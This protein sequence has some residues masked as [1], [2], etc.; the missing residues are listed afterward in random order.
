[1]ERATAFLLLAKPHF[2]AL[3]ITESDQIGLTSFNEFEFN[4]FS[5]SDDSDT[6]NR[7]APGRFDS[8]GTEGADYDFIYGTGY[9]PLRAGE[10]QRISLAVVFGET[11]DD[12]LENLSTVQT[13]YD[14]NYN[15]IQP[16]AK[17][18]VTAVP[19][20]GQVTL[21]W[22]DRAEFSVDRVSH[23]RD[24]QGYRIYRATDAGFLDNY[25]I[26]DGQ[27]TQSAFLPVAQFDLVDDVEGYFAIPYRGTQYYLGD[28]SGLVHSWVDTTAVNGRS[29]FYAVTSYDAGDEVA[30]FLPAECAK[31]ASLDAGG[32]VTL[33]VNTAYVTPTA[34]V[35]GYVPPLVLAEA[36]HDIGDATGLV[37]PAIVDET[38]LVDGGTYTI[39]MIPD[40]TGRIEDVVGWE[41][42]EYTPDS[43]W[44]WRWN[45]IIGDSVWVLEV[46]EIPYDSV[47]SLL[48]EVMVPAFAWTMTREGVPPAQEVY[49]INTETPQQGLAHAGVQAEGFEARLLSYNQI[50]EVNTRLDTGEVLDS[51]GVIDVNF[52]SGLVVFLDPFLDTLDTETLYEVQFTYYYNLVHKQLCLDLT[53]YQTTHSNYFPVVEGV[54]VEFDNDWDIKLDSENSGWTVEQVGDSLVMPWSLRLANLDSG[55]ITFLRGTAIPDNYRLEVVDPGTGAYARSP[56]VFADSTR[57]PRV[58]RNLLPG[59]SSMFRL[60]KVVGDNETPVQFWIYNPNISLSPDDDEHRS[61]D[62]EAEPIHYGDNLLFYEEADGDSVYSWTLGSVAGTPESYL[63]PAVGN[64]YYAYTL[65]PF[66][67]MDRY[68]FIVQGADWNVSTSGTELSDIR[69]VPNPYI[70]S[71]VWEEAPISGNRGARKIQFIHLPPR[72]TVRVYTVRGELVQTLYHDE[73][74]WDGSLDWNLKSKEGLDVAT[75]MYFYHVDSP[76]GEHRGKFALIK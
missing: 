22:D 6:W 8:T 37:S 61:T 62:V 5:P 45:N 31:Q 56:Q 40:T 25:V 51:T 46:S 73:E 19:G 57:Y 58:F 49:S 13:I 33:D 34:P 64:E 66:D 3:D 26:T 43:T 69:V 16:P 24:F 60:Y 20:D 65:R 54:R 2:D 74:V 9:F 52:D 29:Y 67:K 10:T 44:R 68:S 76:A 55:G 4:E 75:G 1:M 42:T 38:A 30:G 50:L 21:Y 28:N 63:Y 48:G 7:M 70:A 17:P 15:F 12:I 71:A 39:S 53:G 14:E 36:S 18:I 72:C 11:E 47:R 41:Y 32:L 35:S 23:L 27:G 59:H